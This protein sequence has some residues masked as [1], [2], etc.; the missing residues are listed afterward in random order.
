MSALATS[1]KAYRAS[2]VQ[3]ASS[4]QLI[5]MLY[6]GARKFLFQARTAMEQGD[7]ETAHFKL[8]RGEDIIVYLQSILDMEQGQIS[9]R[10][11][12]IYG[13]CLA[14]LNEARKD[15]NPRK[16]DQVSD[17]L[18]ELRGAWARASEL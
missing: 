8:R 14:H 4:G 13:F 17:Q 15:Q 16:I 7:V 1:P 6:D 9:E 12:L 5:V 3:T 18:L 10:L 11:M 2:A